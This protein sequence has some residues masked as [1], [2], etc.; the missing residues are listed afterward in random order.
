MTDNLATESISQLE[1][2]K[3]VKKIS[4]PSSKMK[5]LG[6]YYTPQNVSKIICQK[7]LN[8][9]HFARVLEPSCGNGSFLKNIKSK[10]I[11]KLVA[12]ERDFQIAT[13]VRLKYQSSK[14]EIIHDDFLNYFEGNKS[15]KFDLIIGNP[16]FIKYSLMTKKQATLGKSL[17]TDL[18]INPSIFSNCWEL[19]LILSLNLLEKNGTICFILPYEI[20]Q[21]NYAENLKKILFKHLN[22]VEFSII[23]E[24]IFPD[25]QQR[26]VIFKGINNYKKT[27]TYFKNYR[28]VS[29]FEKDIPTRTTKFTVNEH[30]KK[31][32]AFDSLGEKINQYNEIAHLFK[33]AK[34]LTE[35]HTGIVT[36][37]NAYFIKSAQE[38]KKYKLNKFKKLI[39][40]KGSCVNNMLIV[41]KADILKLNKLAVPNYLVSIDNKEIPKAYL[42]IGKK[43]DIHTRYKS[44]NRTPWY[45]VPITKSGE[46]LFFK[47][48]SKYPKLILNEDKIHAT[49]SAYCIHMRE[50]YDK[51]SF[52]ASFYNSLT[53]MYCELLGRSYGGGVLELTPNEFRELPIPYVK[54][55]KNDVRKLDSMLRKN[56][57]LEQIIDF[58]DTTVLIK[59]HNF[60]KATV[61]EISTARKLLADNRYK[62]YK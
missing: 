14:I 62:I 45:K 32:S 21:T 6:A 40:Q 12:I 8:N 24:N 38:I 22:Y 29:D 57:S 2:N 16:P 49:D 59:N 53:L 1:N 5:N 31:W 23:E 15:K 37:A 50:G 55:K 54:L 3:V 60:S 43:L 52:L 36:G 9:K 28:T 39:I 20:L 18:N 13:S 42:K 19:F 48:C 61:D 11:Q 35:N 46:L 10:N 30:Q 26:V 25:L 47:R 56:K 17:L 33:R 51:F 4:A 41:K 27:G 34:D 44:R 58:I 7:L